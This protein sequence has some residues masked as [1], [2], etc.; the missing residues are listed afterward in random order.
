[1]A[2]ETIIASELDE[3][4]RSSRVIDDL[5]YRR[6]EAARILLKSS[7]HNGVS[8]SDRH[9]LASIAGIMMGLPEPES[10]ARVD[11]AIGHRPRS[12]IAPASPPW[13]RPSSLPSRYW[14]A[15]SS[16]GTPQ[17]KAARTANWAPIISGIGREAT[18]EAGEQVQWTC[19][20]CERRSVAR[21]SATRGWAEERPAKPVS[22]SGGPAK[23]AA[24]RRS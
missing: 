23:A 1:M 8:N 19:E 13:C 6:A 15:P 18:G 20:S 5:S 9:Y 2:G 24:V 14:S 7:S 16:L 11:D 10:R 12:C 4:F 3:L 17:L 21:P 22:R